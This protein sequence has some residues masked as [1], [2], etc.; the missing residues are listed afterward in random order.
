LAIAVHALL[1]D[2]PAPFIADHEAMQIKV[3]TVLNGGAVDFCRQST[4][5]CQ[6]V[7]IEANAVAES[8]KLAR[9]QA[10]MLAAAAADAQAEFA[11]QGVKTALE[12]PQHARRDAGGMPI[13]PHQRAERLKPE[14]MR[15]AA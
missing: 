2:R 7:T 12:R 5:F 3:E 4:G 13:H 9:R 1:H 15:H 8:H 14:R 6:R 11:A 10:R